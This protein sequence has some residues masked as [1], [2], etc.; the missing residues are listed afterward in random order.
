MEAVDSMPINHNFK[1]FRQVLRD[2]INKITGDLILLLAKK[3][4]GK[5]TGK[6]VKPAPKRS[7]SQHRQRGIKSGHKPKTTGKPNLKLLFT[8]I[9]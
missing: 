6:G 1:R 9:L 4:G 2:L 3:G 7:E 8:R 5:S